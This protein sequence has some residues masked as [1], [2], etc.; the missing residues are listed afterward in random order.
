MCGRRNTQQI[1]NQ[2]YQ[3]NIK[4]ARINKLGKHLHSKNVITNFKI[5]SADYLT[6]NRYPKISMGKHIGFYKKKINN[7]KLMKKRRL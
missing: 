7:Y 3:K 6:T 5:L 4:Q 1:I 2:Y